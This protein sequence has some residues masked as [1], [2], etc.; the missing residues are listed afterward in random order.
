MSNMVEFATGKGK[1]NNFVTVA[2][3]QELAKRQQQKQDRTQELYR[4]IFLY[5]APELKLHLKMN[6]GKIGQY[7]GIIVPSHIPIDVDGVNHDSRK[8]RER[9]Q[10]LLTRLHDSAGIPPECVQ[11]FFSGR[12]LHALIHRDLFGMSASPEL[13]RVVRHMVDEMLMGFEGYDQ[14]YNRTAIFRWPNTWNLSAELFKIPLTF[15]EV[16]KW[17]ID[18]IYR[19]AKGPR[20]DFDYSR[21]AESGDMHDMKDLATFAEAEVF[22]QSNLEN[23]TQKPADAEDPMTSNRRKL[24]CLHNMFEAGP[25]DGTRHYMVGAISC[26]WARQGIP[27]RATIS[28]L[29]TWVR[30][31]DGTLADNEKKYSPKYIEEQVRYWY[32]GGYRPSCTGDNKYSGVMQAHCDPE[33]MFFKKKN[34]NH[35]MLTVDEGFTKLERRLAMERSG[36]YIDLSSILDPNGTQPKLKVFPGTLITLMGPTSVGKTSFMQW[37]AIK[38]RMGMAYLSLEMAPAMMLKRFCQQVLGATDTILDELYQKY[39]DQVQEALSHIHLTSEAPNIAELN[40]LMASMGHRLAII[41][42]IGLMQTFSSDERRRIIEVTRGL[43]QMVVQSEYIIFMLSHIGRQDARSGVV[44]LYSGK[45]SGSIENDSHIVLSI[46]DVRDNPRLRQVTVLKNT[47]G[48][49]GQNYLLEFDMDTY[50]FTPISP[51]LTPTKE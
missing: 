10:A 33:C 17:D 18:A 21:F 6:N 28:A 5:P 3:F 8:S 11:Y 50:N 19:L 32:R 34:L 37:M 12:G 27:M 26:G 1:R 35:G 41:D 31:G 48:P 29:Q 14:I 45:E 36:N 40:D 15:E 39:R 7:D 51:K 47:D 24:T 20:L 9:V 44:D 23:L 2:Q 25:Q 16:S 49:R 13:H 43:R 38:I 42:H 46:T 30:R 22:A 4:S